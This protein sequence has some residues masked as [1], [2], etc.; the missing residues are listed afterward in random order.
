MRVAFRTDASNAIGSG[1]IMRCL[2]LAGELRH[3]GAECAFV[4]REH[5]GNLI[6]QI[7]EHGYWVE[8]LPVLDDNTGNQPYWLGASTESDARATGEFLGK[9]KPDWL[10]IDHYAIDAEWE[11]LVTEGAGKLLV[12]DDLAN[13]PHIPDVLLDQNLGRMEEDYVGLIP[14]GARMLIGPRF[15]LLRSEFGEWREASLLKRNVAS[16][17]HVLVTMGG[18]DAADATSE[19]LELIRGSETRGIERVTVVMGSKAV[20]RDKV[21]SEARAMPIPTTVL[22]GVRDMAKLMSDADLAIGAGGSTSWERCCLGLPAIQLALA[23][24][25]V[26]LS[27]SL[28][29]EGAV[30]YAGRVG[31]TNW[32][33]HFLQFFQQ[34]VVEPALLKRMSSRA[35]RIVDGAGAGR[36]AG[37]MAKLEAQH[38]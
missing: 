23:D 33:E 4:C 26:F 17:K 3:R 19:V 2:T 16:V 36:V 14:G 10:V 32:K 30:M 31:D 22:V 24:N 28:N 34:L 38:G 21:I 6:E 35:S 18:A 8:P 29:G 15:A 9:F 12:I 1:H 5:D 7:A 27:E 37:V 20:W 11:R 13:R 25:Q